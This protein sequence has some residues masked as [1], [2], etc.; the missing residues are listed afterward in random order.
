MHTEFSKA[1]GGSPDVNF[2]VDRPNHVRFHIPSNGNCAHRVY[3]QICTFQI[4]GLHNL[5]VQARYI[6]VI[7]LADILGCAEF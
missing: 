5:S 4:S 2:V 6:Q 1:R 3:I 7:L